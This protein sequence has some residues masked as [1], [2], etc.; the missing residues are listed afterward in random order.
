MQLKCNECQM[1]CM[2]NEIRVEITTDEL[3]NI[4]YLGCEVVE[5]N[6][7]VGFHNMHV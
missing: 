2:T 3:E 4:S 6:M 5:E 7:S 1:K